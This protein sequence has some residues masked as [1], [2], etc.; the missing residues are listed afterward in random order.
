MAVIIYVPGFSGKTARALAEA[1]GIRA[2][3][4]TPY[5]GKI[6]KE[7]FA[8][9]WGSS[10]PQ[11]AYHSGQYLNAPTSIEIAADKRRTLN[12]AA[13]MFSCT[14]KVLAR[15]GTYPFRTIWRPLHHR[16]GENLVVVE[17][18]DNA[19]GWV[20]A[21]W[22]GTQFVEATDEYRIHVFKSKIILA[23]HKLPMGSYA[24]PIIRSHN[25]GWKFVSYEPSNMTSYLYKYPCMIIERL[26][27]DF[28]AVDMLKSAAGYHFLEVNTAPGLEGVGLD[29][30][31]KS[32]RQVMPKS[33]Q[34]NMPD[35]IPDN[36]FG[37]ALPVIRER[38][39]S[40]HSAG[41]PRGWSQTDNTSRATIYE[42]YGRISN[43]RDT[44]DV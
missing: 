29:A 11:L 9:F 33:G 5:S 21:T 43:T 30:Y 8:I 2:M 25:R 36:M 20:P 31:V 15:N 1:L 18:G 3:A 17:A 35:N 28:G 42:T 6:S 4:A 23:Q 37:N 32:F 14:P 7:D 41:E 34:I 16:G 44:D 24:D 22:F 10:A 39:D 12:I 19:P 40:I 13:D 27:L 38:I 26:R